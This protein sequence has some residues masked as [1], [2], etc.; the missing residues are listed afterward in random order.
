MIYVPTGRRSILYHLV[1]IGPMLYL[2]YIGPILAGDSEVYSITGYLARSHRSRL[3][4]I[5]VC[6]NFGLLCRHML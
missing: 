3:L 5:V 6:Q 1:Y 2:V 4:E